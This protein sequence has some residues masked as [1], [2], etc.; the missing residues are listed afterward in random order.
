MTI[1]ASARDL[2]YSGPVITLR[3]QYGQQIQYNT[4]RLLVSLPHHTYCIRTVRIFNQVTVYA[5]A[6]YLELLYTINFFH[7]SYGFHL[8]K[9]PLSSAPFS[10][11]FFYSK[12]ACRIYLWRGPKKE[13]EQIRYTPHHSR[14]PTPAQRTL[15]DSRY[16]LFRSA[17]GHSRKTPPSDPLS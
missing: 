13:K 15:K 10:F 8:F 17:D 3:V 4:I 5:P 7:I 1:S 16:M 14:A 2:Q 6:K 9:T 12:L 11:L